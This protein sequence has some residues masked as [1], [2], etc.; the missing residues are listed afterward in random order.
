MSREPNSSLVDR[1]YKLEQRRTRQRVIAIA[2]ISM[3]IG[4]AMV[5]FSLIRDH[6]YYGSVFGNKISMMIT[7]MWIAFGL[8]WIIAGYLIVL[9]QYQAARVFYFIVFALHII[10]I[11]GSFYLIF[12]VNVLTDTGWFSDW[13]RLA[14]P[15][16]IGAILAMLFTRLLYV[17]VSRGTR[18]RRQ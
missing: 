5:P 13:M 17:R 14:W 3:F 16:V 18:V 6:I 7:S 1:K 15:S 4:V 12:A 11:I 9:R 2:M 8:F 10:H